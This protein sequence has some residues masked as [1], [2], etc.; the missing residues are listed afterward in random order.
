MAMQEHS[1]CQPGRP[2]PSEVSQKTSPSSGLKDF[3]RAKSRRSFLSYS[4]A[5][6]RAAVSDTEEE[7]EAEE[8]EAEDIGCDFSN[9]ARR[10]Y[11]SKADTEK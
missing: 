3:H 9:W 1:I 11:D 6:V 4:S 2:F 7:A 5:S 10:P 8:A